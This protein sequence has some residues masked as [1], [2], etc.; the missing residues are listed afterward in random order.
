M[1]RFYTVFILVA[2]SLGFIVSGCGDEDGF[3]ADST[4]ELSVPQQVVFPETPLKS[5]RSQTVVLENTGTGPLNIRKVNIQE[6]DNDQH[7]ELKP[8]NKWIDQA[9]TI[10]AGES[11]TIE[12]TFAPKNTA[13]IEGKLKIRSNALNAKSNGWI[14]VDLV[15]PEL[16]PK[17]ASRSVVNFSNVA[18]GSSK[19]KSLKVQNVGTA[20]LTFDDILLETPDGA[21]FELKYPNHSSDGSGL[22]LQRLAPRSSLQMDIVFSPSDTSSAVNAILFKT[23]DP[24]SPM[25]KVDL[26]GN[27]NSACLETSLRDKLAF[28]DVQVG[29]SETKTRTITNCSSSS[30][31]VIQTLNLTE[32][33]GGSFELQ[34]TPDGLPSLN[35]APGETIR[36]S[37]AFTPQEKKSFE[38]NLRVKS[39]DPVNEVMNISLEGTGVTGDDDVVDCGD[40]NVV[41]VDNIPDMRRNQIEDNCKIKVFPEKTNFSGGVVNVE[42]T[43]LLEGTL[44]SEPTTVDTSE[45]PINVY[46]V[47]YDRVDARQEAEV[48]VGRITFDNEVIG[49]IHGSQMLYKTNKQLNICEQFNLGTTDRTYCESENTKYP[50]FGKDEFRYYAFEK[51]EMERSAI[52]GPKTIKFD[53]R[54]KANADNARVITKAD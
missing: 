14:V 50:T 1:N 49:L 21:D 40:G 41:R 54:T 30:D 47:H 51:G 37:M 28:G 7:V 22:P 42:T 15:T 29:E 33:G 31:L 6:N 38:G 36:F 25:Y 18:P 12:V 10:P 17:I 16:G 3:G 11:K 13:A 2:A 34:N 26:R 48:A 23:N 46:G 4:A 45:Q 43:R 27:G 19:T 39:N 52:I 5:S 20:P 8:G 53:V 32:T 9:T 24:V 44:G 35:V